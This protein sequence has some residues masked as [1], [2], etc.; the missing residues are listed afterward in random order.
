MGEV[1]VKGYL[2]QIEVIGRGLRG[3][4]CTRSLQHRTSS[5][6]YHNCP[7]C[8]RWEQWVRLSWT[9]LV[10]WSRPWRQSEDNPFDSAKGYPWGMSSEK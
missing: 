10:N 1:M 9:S 2:F 8:W 3:A 7:A 6:L 5:G 4:F